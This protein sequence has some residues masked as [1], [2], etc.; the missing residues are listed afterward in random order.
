[1]K[2]NQKKSVECP[3]RFIMKLFLYFPQYSIKK[4]EIEINT[5]KKKQARIYHVKRKT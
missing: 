1:M 5:L 3:R 2:D 4:K